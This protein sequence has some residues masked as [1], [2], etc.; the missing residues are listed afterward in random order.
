MC[1]CVFSY[2]PRCTVTLMIQNLLSKKSE[3]PIESQQFCEKK[4]RRVIALEVIFL[5]YLSLSKIVLEILN[6]LMYVNVNAE[7]NRK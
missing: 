5:R 7:C 2:R 6:T 1:G 3:F 4:R